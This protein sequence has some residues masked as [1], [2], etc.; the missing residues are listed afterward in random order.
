MN[1]GG[2]TAGGAGGCAGSPGQQGHRA[3][4]IFLC[5]ANP[6]RGRHAKNPDG[7]SRCSAAGAQP[8]GRP[9]RATD[10]EEAWRKRR[11]MAAGR[12]SHPLFKAVRG[13]PGEARTTAS[14]FQRFARRANGW[15]ADGGW[16]GRMPCDEGLGQHDPPGCSATGQWLRQEVINANGRKQFTG[17]VGNLF[18]RLR[19]AVARKRS[20]CAGWGRSSGCR[21][22][23]GCVRR[24][25][26]THPARAR[27]SPATPAVAVPYCPAL[28]ASARSRDR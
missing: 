22:C 9:E 6:L 18:T 28:A 14:W 27:D 25:R 10:L 1:P 24:K 21:S 17:P 4:G 5:A 3:G 11:N 26:R 7:T 16:R 19:V 2:A 23:W 13:T 20:L 8:R 12:G 15:R